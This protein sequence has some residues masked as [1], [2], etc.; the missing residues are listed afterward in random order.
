M[1]EQ[2]RETRKILGSTGEIKSKGA[3]QARKRIELKHILESE[4][5]INNVREDNHR[6]SIGINPETS[7]LYYRNLDRPRSPDDEGDLGDNCQEEEAQS[8][9]VH[10][11]N[12][13]KNIRRSVRKDPNK[14]LITQYQQ[15]TNE[16]RDNVAKYKMHRKQVKSFSSYTHVSYASQ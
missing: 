14:A 7:S 10:H 9:N 1:N 11:S 6:N 13:F 15:A 4:I 12:R 16:H 8:E 2:E 5:K 3:S